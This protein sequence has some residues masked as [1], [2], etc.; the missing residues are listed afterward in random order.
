MTTA[1]GRIVPE[2][3]IKTRPE[4]GSRY[5][6]HRGSEDMFAVLMVCSCSEVDDE[7]AKGVAFDSGDGLHDI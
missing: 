2:E 5:T 3:N 6:E 4:C 7:L 1:S